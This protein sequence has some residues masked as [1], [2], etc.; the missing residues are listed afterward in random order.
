M[1]KPMV[2]IIVNCYNGSTTLKRALDSIFAQSYKD[3]EI[4]FWDNNSIDASAEIAISYGKKIKYYK[5]E[6]TTIL[7]AARGMALEKCSGKYVAFLDCDDIWYPSKLELQIAKIEGSNYIV[8]YAGVKEITSDGDIIRSIIP[9]YKDGHQF[10]DHLKQF[11]INMVTPLINLAAMKLN[12]I[13]FDEN[14]VASAEYNIFMRLALVGEFCSVKE[15]LGEWTVYE[16][17]LTNQSIESWSKDRRHTLDRI[18]SENLDIIK[19]Y[20]KE[21]GIAYGGSDYYEARYLIS[22]DKWKEARGLLRNNALRTKT[23]FILWL[24][25][26]IP[27]LWRLLHNERIKRMLSMHVLRKSKSA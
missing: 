11:D 20:P 17:S 19:L 12:N 15:I 6:K 9:K 5:S 7:G 3:W 8:C 13:T 14:I 1:Q 23:F 21:L 4:I 10:R 25:S 27:S 2:S 26:M 18:K 16:N 24:L 22:C